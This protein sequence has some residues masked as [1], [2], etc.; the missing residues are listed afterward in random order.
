MALARTAATLQS[1]LVNEMKAE[2][3]T[4]E[5]EAQA[6]DLAAALRRS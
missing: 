4:A 6:N 1:A 2:R 3:E 5:R